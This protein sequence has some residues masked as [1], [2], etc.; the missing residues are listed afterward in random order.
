MNFKLTTLKTII[1][2]I[3]GLVLGFTLNLLISNLFPTF[4]MIKSSSSWETFYSYSTTIFWLVEVVGI[5][6]VYFIWSLIQK[7]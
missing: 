6:I 5:I 7:K 3:I 4:A 2:I 1:S